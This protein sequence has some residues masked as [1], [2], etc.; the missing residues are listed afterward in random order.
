M[1]C[2]TGVYWKYTLQYYTYEND[3]NGRNGIGTPLR[4][5]KYTLE[6]EGYNILTLIK[7]IST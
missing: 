2:F 5:D 7:N 3:S 4:S 1:L 6:L